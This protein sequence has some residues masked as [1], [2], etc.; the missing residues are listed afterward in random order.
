M[1]SVNKLPNENNA[2]NRESKFSFQLYYTYKTPM[3][4]YS[5]IR[6]KFITSLRL[7]HKEVPVVC[8]K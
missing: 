7:H 2:N 6:I 5:L 8:L 3:S 1:S 4:G